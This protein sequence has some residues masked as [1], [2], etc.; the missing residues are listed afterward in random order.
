MVWQHPTKA[1]SLKQ[2]GDH[3]PNGLLEQALIWLCDL[4]IN[5]LRVL[6]VLHFNV[7]KPI[8]LMTLL[9][10]FYTHIRT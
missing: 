7:Y 5:R 1:L 2:A 6:I 9:V 8:M 10:I 3:N 4:H